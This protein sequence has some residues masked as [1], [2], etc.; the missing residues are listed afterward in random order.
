MKSAGENALH[1]VIEADG[2]K[3]FWGADGAWFLCKTWA[4]MRRMKPYDRVVLD[5]T[6]GDND[7]DNR[8]FEHNNLT[9]VGNIRKNLISQQML[10]EGGQVWLTHLSRDEHIDPMNLGVELNRRGFYMALDDLEDEF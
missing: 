1:Y 6:L 2:R 9:M 4:S 7:D 10:T 3:I 5:C 8:I